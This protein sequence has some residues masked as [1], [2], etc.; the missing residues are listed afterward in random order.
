LETHIQ[1][2]W[3]A[4]G[5]RGRMRDNGVSRL[6]WMGYIASKI[7][8]LRADV[9]HRILFANSDYRS[10]LLERNSTTNSVVVLSSVLKVTDTFMTRGIKY[11]RACFRDFMKEINL[12]GGHKNLAA[13]EQDGLIEIISPL[14]EKCY[15]RNRQDA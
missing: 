13:I 14:Y 4:K 12:L 3:F 5:V 15:T 11:D 1:N 8:G 6:W 10:Q 2:H 7:P 9:I